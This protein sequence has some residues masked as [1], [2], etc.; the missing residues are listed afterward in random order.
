[1]QEGARV[2]SLG[3]VPSAAPQNEGQGPAMP[4][5]K[6]GEMWWG[7]SIQTLLLSAP[8]LAM[9]GKERGVSGVTGGPFAPSGQGNTRCW[10][11]VAAPHLS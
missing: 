7:G 2:H 4:W 5:G 9:P 11:L 6:R 3:R 1:M 10:H 8:V